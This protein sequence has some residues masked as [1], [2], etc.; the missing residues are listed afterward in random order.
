MRRESVTV[1][2]VG[3]ISTSTDAA[4]RMAARLAAAAP[5]LLALSIA[6]RFAW[7]YLVPNGANFVDLHV[8]VGGAGALDHPGTLYDYVYA[9]QT[10][11]FPLP[12]TYPPFAAVLFYPLHLLPF[13]LVSFAWTL[14][15]I[16]AL[17]GVVRLSQRLLP[18][19]ENP[20]RR[21]AM[22][23]TAVGMW[24]EPLRS[25][26]DYGQ[27]NVLL[28]LAVLYAVYSTRWWVSGL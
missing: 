24:T 21:L 28:V 25:T 16:A 2:R 6:A 5:V 12:F 26:F 8:Y 17:Y 27:V 23:W 19:S 4:P 10:P 11:D 13:G 15:I 1:A 20:S 3:Q 18:G 7:T 9:D 22:T 14:G